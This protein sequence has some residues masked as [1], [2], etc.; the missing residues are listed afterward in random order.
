[1]VCGMVYDMAPKNVHFSTSQTAAIYAQ[2][3]TQEKLGGREAPP[4]L[5]KV[6]LVAEF[7][8]F[9]EFGKGALEA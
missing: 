9:Q 6:R 4:E 8:F 7:V 1:M 2:H 5:P 3:Y